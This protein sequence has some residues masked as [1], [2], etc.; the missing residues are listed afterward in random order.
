[1]ATDIFVGSVAVGVVPDIRQW[2]NRL[3][4]E[5]VPSANAV[6]Q[7]FGQQ[8]SRQIT[9]NMGKAGSSSGGAFS[10]NF[11]KRVQAAIENLPKAKIDGDS[12]DV[13][14]KIQELRNWLER[15][16]TIDIINNKQALADISS[17][18]AELTKIAS[19]ADGIDIKFNTTEAKA[20]LALLQRDIDKSTSAGSSQGLI[21]RLAASSAPSGPGGRGL[22]LTGGIASS[23][24]LLGLAGPLAAAGLAGGAGL[25]VALPTLSKIHD[26]MTQITA[27]Q[28]A[29]N[30]AT[31]AAARSTA[32]QHI[33]DD[34][35]ALSG[36]QQ[37]AIKA[38]QT[39]TGEWDKLTK[40]LQPQ[41]F[42]LVTQA[43]TGVTQLLPLLVPL[44][45]AGFGAISAALTPLFQFLQSGLFIQFLQAVEIYAAP[46]A[47]SLVQLFTAIAGPILKLITDI[48][49]EG[50][51]LMT[52]FSGFAGQVF[53][54]LGQTIMEIVVV[55]GPALGQLLQVLGPALVN[56]FAALAGPMANV[57]R[58]FLDLVT[59]V[60][61]FIGALPP[62]VIVAIAAAI[63]LVVLALKAWAIV[64][65]IL[66]VLM[67]PEELLIGAIIVAVALLA[68]GIFELVK[69]WTQAWTDIKNWTVD[70]W[71]A[72]YNEVIA[73]M[74]RFFLQTVPQW[75]QNVRNWTVNSWQAIYNEVIAPMARFFT[76]L[77]PGWWSYAYQAIVRN[78]LQ[79]IKNGTIEAW[80]WVYN[81]VWA[82]VH[83]FLFKTIPSWWDAGYGFVRDHF[84]EPFKNGIKGGWDWVVSHVFNPI[85][86]FLTKTIPGWFDTAVSN[87]KTAWEKIANTMASPVNWVI[88]NVLNNLSKGFNTIT[89]ALGLNINIGMIPQIPAFHAQRG[90]MLPGYGGG[91]KIPIMAEAGEMV[92]PKEAAGHPLARMLASAY[93]VPGFQLGGIVGN[94]AHA[95]L[96]ALGQLVPGLGAVG[97]LLS[98]PAETWTA[99]MATKAIDKLAGA[100][101]GGVTG[102]MKDILGG[103]V[104][105]I[106]GGMKA[107]LTTNMGGN[108]G[109]VLA[110]AMS[111]LGKVP[112]VWGG[113][114]TSG[115]DCSGFVSY[116]YRH[117][118]I[119]AGRMV[120]EGFRQWA[121]PSG[122]EPGAL[123]FYGNPAHHVGFVKDSNT[124]LSA[125]G[126]GY[127]TTLSGLNMGD[128]SGYGIPPAGYGKASG[129]GGSGPTTSG[130]WVNVGREMAS[131]YGWTGTEFDFLNMLW[132]KESNWNPSAQNPTS[133]AAGIPQDIT[134]NFHGGGYGQI[135]WGLDY[136]KG[137]YGDPATAW[138]HEILYNWYDN[139]GWLPPGATFAY[140]GTGKPELILTHDQL[141]SAAQRGG[142]GASYH[143]HF[144]GLTGQLIEGHVRTAFQ[145][146]SI[147][148][149]NMERQGRRR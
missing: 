1:M 91:D 135:Q 93:R 121:K 86:D 79:P 118:N 29:Y 68:F 134:G 63:G 5:L 146:M 40:S 35:A 55:A 143:A 20:Q 139:G 112:Y 33:H 37:A 19:K 106:A 77:I 34:Y 52:I 140:N 30:R 32:L 83:D 67:A 145:A 148:Q 22:A 60:V 31:T 142:D 56:I 107:Y 26:S 123:A 8:M 138:A 51:H 80:Q 90:I 114:Q 43:I 25:A 124:L 65:A 84:I 38:I 74:A 72:I 136:I 104:S 127:G 105:K 9:E 141:M 4:A 27:D 62:D 102:V 81:H 113:D 96:H 111:F 87:I 117:F 48:M 57:L 15:L 137:R 76:Q 54:A 18:E 94:I 122:P 39:F 58:I 98:G 42:G 23:I 71:H 16:G 95:G 133:P 50:I 149:G 75:W 66:N 3:R 64:Q 36:P 115:W 128:N 99:D 100:G 130:D 13:D 116:V 73:P 147:S 46:A 10:D 24:P 61:R 12:T 82:P 7:E 109:S 28:N 59:P 11:R 17:I 110:Y 97:A 88:N 119:M 125:L 69:H 70:T 2:N 126:T 53:G 14:R 6:G 92:L 45:K 131:R 41:V 49:P 132:T 21:A 89:H 85:H 103:V 101:L 144:D 78:F 120:A 129:G 108:G 44:A 47:A